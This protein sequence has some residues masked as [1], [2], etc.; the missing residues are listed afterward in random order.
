MFHGMKS[1]GSRNSEHVLVLREKITTWISA[2]VAW[3]LEMNRV[4]CYLC[5]VA[6]AKNSMCS[7]RVLEKEKGLCLQPYALLSK[8][9][10]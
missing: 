5:P 3:V 2:H 9:S 4:L 8:D 7:H 10:K 6:S 1:T